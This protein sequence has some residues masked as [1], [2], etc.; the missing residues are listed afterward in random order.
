MYM[1]ISQLGTMTRFVVVASQQLLG[2]YVVGLQGGERFM[3]TI[4]VTISVNRKDPTN[5]LY[6]PALF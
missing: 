2:V 6:Q 5:L 4:T 1:S 3:E